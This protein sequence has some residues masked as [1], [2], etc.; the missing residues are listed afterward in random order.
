MK[1][2]K[3]TKQLDFRVAL[4]AAQ[5]HKDLVTIAVNSCSTELAKLGLDYDTNCKLFA[6][7]GSLEIPLTAKLLAETGDWDAVIAFGLVVD[8]SIYRHEFV[9]QT[10]LDGIIHVSLETNIPVLSV[11]LT[12]QQFD[13]QNIEHIKFFSQHLITKGIE[14]AHAAIQTMQLTRSLRK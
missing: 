11:V 1:N 10:V 13:E 2:K 7:P 4:I 12:P 5:W 6:V 3:T 14:A 8:G 9:A